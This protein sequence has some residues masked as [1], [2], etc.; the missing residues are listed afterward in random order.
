MSAAHRP[1]PPQVGDPAPS[2][3]PEDHQAERHLRLERELEVAGQDLEDQHQAEQERRR[4]RVRSPGARIDQASPQAQG[5]QH[6]VV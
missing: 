6:P 1:P 5:I 4:P 2:D 3:R